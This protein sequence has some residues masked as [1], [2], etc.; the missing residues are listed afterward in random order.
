MPVYLLP[1]PR[2]VDSL[3]VEEWGFS[4]LECLPVGSCAVADVCARGL[5]VVP[6]RRMFCFGAGGMTE[7]QKR[8]LGTD[9]TD[10]LWGVRIRS[11]FEP[12]SGFDGRAIAQP[13]E[14]MDTPQTAS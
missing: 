9:G 8:F 13:R 6:M 7:W 4:A 10:S 11:E 1:Y 14:D 12:V 5:W 2:L 3:R